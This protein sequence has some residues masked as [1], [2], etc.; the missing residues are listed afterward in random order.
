MEI[1]Q[2]QNSLAS[3]GVENTELI[4]KQDSVDLRS[5]IL[6]EIDKHTV[7]FNEKD[8]TIRSLNQRLS[9]YELANVQLRLDMAILFPQIAHYSIGVQQYYN[10]RDSLVNYIAFVYQAK[11]DFPE[12]EE[13]K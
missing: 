3:Y 9:R 11:D 6:S 4:I 13:Q 2:L 5:A 8:L 10:T 1:E 7:C 12:E